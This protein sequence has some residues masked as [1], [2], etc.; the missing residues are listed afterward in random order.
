MT[1]ELLLQQHSALGRLIAAQEGA[2]AATA[3]LSESEEPVLVKLT[4][5]EAATLWASRVQRC[6]AELAE[7]RLREE[8]KRD[9][10]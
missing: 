4:R 6:E 1:K 3:A 9:E 5:L 8:E 2:E 7:L 10:I